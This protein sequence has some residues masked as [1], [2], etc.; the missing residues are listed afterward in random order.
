MVNVTIYPYGWENETQNGSE[1]DYTCQH[2]PEECRGNLIEN[3]GKYYYTESN[4]FW[5]WLVCLENGA[6]TLKDF[7]TIGEQ[8]ATQY[9]LDWSEV[10]D[11]ANGELG[12]Q[13][14][15]VAGEVTLALEPP[16]GWT[17]WVVVNGE[18][19]VTVENEIYVDFLGWACS[20]FQGVKP[21]V[22]NEQLLY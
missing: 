14:T 2:G 22:C 3:C 17:P 8:C 11:C 20:N 1:W 19:F 9:G 4:T 12:N 5:T 7:D 16:R 13:L 10:L 18:P 15:H 6:K 21:S